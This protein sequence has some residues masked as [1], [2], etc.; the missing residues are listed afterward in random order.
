MTESID[1]TE[2]QRAL[3]KSTWQKV[4]AIAP[5]A[6]TLFYD[7]LFRINPS[8]RTLFSTTDMTAQKQKLLHALSAVVHS[9]DRVENICPLL[10]ELG[11]RHRD[12]GVTESH[13][14][15]VGSALIETLRTGLGDQWTEPV[16]KAWLAAY[17]MVTTAML[18]K[19][20]A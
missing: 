7:N 14:V 10:E 13:Y 4:E 6:A 2:A 3:V 5:Q 20:L 17:T 12:Y 1:M 9:I 8:L 19:H 16:H 18:R 11:R 15:D